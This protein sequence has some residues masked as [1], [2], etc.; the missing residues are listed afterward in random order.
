[1]ATFQKFHKFIE[2]LTKGS[3]NL[4]TDTYKIALTNTAPTIATDSVFLPG[5]LHPA[6]AAVDGYTT[7]GHSV[8]ISSA[9]TTSGVFTLACTTDITI[10]AGAGGIGPFRYAILYDDTTVDD[11]LISVWDIGSSI[12]LTQT[13]TFLID[14]T[15]SLLTIS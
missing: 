6:P 12:T 2:N 14:I 13:D 10:T 15:T 11:K 3:Y 7:N 5:S 8:T 1:M 4:T 9:T